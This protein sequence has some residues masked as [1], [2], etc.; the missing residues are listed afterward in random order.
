MSTPEKADADIYQVDGEVDQLTEREKELLR[1]EKELNAKL[2]KELIDNP[3]KVPKAVWFIIP[4][5]FCERF[6][7]YGIKPMLTLYYQNAAGLDPVDTKVQVHSFTMMAY[8][9]PLLGAAISDSWLAKYETIIYLSVIYLLGTILL[10]VFSINGLIGQY[11]QL[12]TWA[13]TLPL[14]LIALGT[15]GIKPCVSSHGG[16]QYLPHQK[17]GLDWFFALFYV[18]INV[19]SLI[20]K[21]VT[22]IIKNN[23]TCFGTECYFAAYGLQSILFGVSIVIF[24]CGKKYYRIVP[25]LGEFLPWKALKGS[26]Y[27]A[28]RYYKAKPEERVRRGSWLNFAEE[29]VGALFV[30]EIRLFGRVLGMIWPVLFFWMVY[31]QQSTQWQQQYQYMNKKFGS[32]TLA[33]EQSSIYNTIFIILF[34]PFCARVVYPTAEKLGFRFT[35][36]RRMAIGFF[37]VVLSFAISGILQIFVDSHFDGKTVGKNIVAGPNSLHGA[38]QIPQWI[39]LS[40]GEA[41]LS[42]SGLQ[43]TYTE[44]GRQMRSTSA[45]FWLV[46]TSIGNLVVTVVESGLKGTSVQGPAKYFFYTGLGLFGNLIFIFL[47]RRYTYKED[48]EK[49][50]LEKVTEPKE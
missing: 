38:W 47:A 3:D 49:S 20:T 13:I 1:L 32:L 30:T 14:V 15:G 2:D 40:F 16:D 19:G 44:I 25:A 48:R 39:V 46:T 34:V 10:A 8:F 9:F 35:L 11:G 26:I 45:S 36:L 7:F 17:K 21:N 23:I 18:S 4:N 33:P 42:P 29:T 37:L 31:D 43:F 41:M 5:E 12:P 22:P 28:K 24:I 6:C 27:A 50:D